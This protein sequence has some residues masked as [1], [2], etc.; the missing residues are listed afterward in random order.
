ML[1][2]LRVCGDLIAMTYR[3]RAALA[4]GGEAV[5]GGVGTDWDHPGLFRASV[6]TKSETTAKAIE[7]LRR[8]ATNQTI[9]LAIAGLQEEIVVSD[10]TRSP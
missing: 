2:H 5:G 3:Q 6:G 1:E 10:A 8:G 9:T 7:S 4:G